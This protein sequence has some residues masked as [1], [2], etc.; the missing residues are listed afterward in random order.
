MAFK[1]KK[2][3]KFWLFIVILIVVILGLLIAG[4]VK[5]RPFQYISNQQNK[6]ENKPYV[7]PEVYNL[8]NDKKESGLILRIFV[9]EPQYRDI[10]I[11]S[12]PNFWV[13]YNS[14]S[15]LGLSGFVL[16]EG[17]D[18]LA[19]NQYVKRIYIASH[20]PKWLEIRDS[21]KNEK[22]YVE[23]EIYQRFKDGAY[24]NLLVD[25]YS[26]DGI[27]RV[28]KDI[29]RTE[30][31]QA[32]DY[33]SGRTYFVGLISRKGVAILANNSEV[34]SIRTGRQTL[35][36]KDTVGTIEANYTWFLF[37]YTGIGKTVCVI[38]TGI[39]KSHPYLNGKVIG[40]QCYCGPWW[41]GCCPNSFSSQ[42]GEGAGIDG[43]NAGHGTHMAGIIASINETYRGIAYN[44]NLTIVRVADN[45]GVIK[46]DIID[47]MKWCVDN[48]K[49][50]N[51]SVI[52]YSG[53]SAETYLPGEC[54]NNTDAD[55][56]LD[57]A[58]SHNI[59]MTSSSGNYANLTNLSWPAC[60]EKVIAVGAT[61][62]NDVLQT[63]S[64]R[65]SK[66]KLLAPGE[67]I[68]LRWDP[69]GQTGCTTD[70]L[71]EYLMNC[72]P[73]T[74]QANAHV[75]GAIALLKGL[76]EDLTYEQIEDVF[77][78]TGKP[79]YDSASNRTYSRIDVY[80]AIMAVD[81]SLLQITNLSV[82]NINGTKGIFEFVI[83]N[84]NL[85]NISNISWQAADNGKGIINSTI[86]ISL[87][88]GESARVIFV[89][90][91]TET[92]THNINV[93][94]KAGNLEYSK[95]VSV[96]IG[97]GDLWLKEIN[98]LY[99]NGY[100]K[101]LEFKIRNTGNGSLS[102]INWSFDFDDGT[103]TTAKNL[104]T[105]QAGEEAFVY[106]NHN[107]SQI[108]GYTVNATAFIG[109]NKSTSKTKSISFNIE[110]KKL[111]VLNSSSRRRVFEFVI[112]NPLPMNLN[113]VNW[114]FYFGDTNI[115]NSSSNIILIPNEEIFVL[116]EHNY[117]S[118]DTYHVNATTRNG[119]LI[120]SKNISV[121]VS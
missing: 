54:P 18:S 81:A 17:F 43:I 69:Q 86:N 114:T 117:T 30:E 109:N 25:S 11:N 6:S 26:S 62:K 74:S 61:L 75:A 31:I 40:E 80:K 4:F 65:N 38:D 79:I 23:S 13:N 100:S 63:D 102:N 96:T 106:L 9:S 113:N 95:S 45:N 104:I 50:Y 112:R 68:S 53:G 34:K 37:N 101:V 105:L 2:K 119:T 92:G 77:N 48:Y 33:K 10:V 20:A 111:S 85:T 21:F 70:G 3:W 15:S 73:E 108:T 56:I 64:N 98:D 67:V 110:V 55:S 36:L 84:A 90:N 14:S 87:V 82:M 47:A 7:E 28:I 49:K 58:T 1:R 91:F 39:N 120:D 121:S 93:T 8:F 76:R 103:N 116:A 41:Q 19:K 35:H 72:D 88:F 27:T 99:T 22:L 78:L 46:G 51:I 44:S 107:Y 12:T 32:F 83:M 52:S 118:A 29:S 94:A 57:N 42:S 24:V 97:E 66:L 16:E 71:G 89:Y 59:Q 115:T 5:F 60:E